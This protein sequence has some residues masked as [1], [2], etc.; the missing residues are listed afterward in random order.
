M[1]FRQYFLGELMVS[2]TSIMKDLGIALWI[3]GTGVWKTSDTLDEYNYV[4]LSIWKYTF[5]C[6]PYWLRFWQCVVRYRETG[7]TLY[8]VNCFKQAF[9]FFA[10]L[11]GV[12]YLLNEKG[13]YINKTVAFNI[14]ILITFFA[15]MFG[16]CWDIYVDFGLCR[17]LAPGKTLLRSKILYPKWFYYFAMA[18]NLFMRLA[19]IV[20]Y[21]K[22]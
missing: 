12:G 6:L 5:S 14:T 22:N 2:T 4:G 8:Y 21:F 19:W 10:A 15:S 16:Y 1:R 17:T 3:L 9:G 18:S 11:V 7:M 13:G 20:P